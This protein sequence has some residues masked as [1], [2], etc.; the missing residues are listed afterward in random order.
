[1]ELI[2]HAIHHNS[3]RSGRPF[4]AINCGAIPETLME[5]ELFGH[6]KGAF[7]DATR[8]KKGLFEEAS[9]GTIFLDEI[10]EMPVHLQVKL[11]RALQEQKIRPVGSE[12]LVDVDVRV[13]AATLRDLEQ[14]VSA[15]RFRD[16]LF[17][18]LNVV[19]INIPPLRE[20]KEDITVLIKHFMKKHN[21]RLGLNI[22]QI[23][24][25]A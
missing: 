21:R 9:G 15:G 3:P 14:D 20:R 2:A 6:R 16:D 10:G 24:P 22:K 13:I 5:S 7:T 8:D 4:I 17:Y 12:E 23:T 1:K 11:L 19:A 18:R 25:E